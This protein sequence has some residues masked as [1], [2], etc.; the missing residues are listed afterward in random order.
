M[1]QFKV[2]VPSF[3]SID[4]LPKTLSSIESQTDKDYQVCVIDDASTIS[5]Q[6]EI[7]QEYCLR[8]KWKM[9]FHEKNFGALYGLVH[10]IA[11][12]HCDDDDVIVVIDGDDW[13]AH[14]DVFARLRQ[15]YNQNDVYVTWG[16][17]EIYPE[18]KGH[19]KY[20]QPIPERVISQK[21]FRD[22]PFVF[23][24]PGTFKYYLWRQI[25]DEDLRDENGEY[26][27]LMKDKAT[28]Y[29]MLEMAGHKIQYINEVLYIYNIGN[30]LNDYANTLPQEHQRV[31]TL[32]RNRTKYQTLDLSHRYES[33][34]S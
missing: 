27:L 22:I 28:L 24:H 21:L 15:V 29:P 14:P 31:D 25:K 5:K 16:Q 2:I 30:P 1:K 4:Y 12:F 18:G 26:F 13:L 9:D 20:A 3:N 23:W 11:D 10:A 6:R 34:N 19:I 17:C 7:I 8:N 33:T 32:I